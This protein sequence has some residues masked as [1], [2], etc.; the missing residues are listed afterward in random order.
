MKKSLQ[1]EKW[2]SLILLFVFAAVCTGAVND[3][4][5]AYVGVDTQNSILGQAYITLAD[6]YGDRRLQI[7]LDSIDTFSNFMI[8]YYNL[9]PRLQW[10]ATIYD[11]RS[12][13]IAGYDP[14]SFRPQ[15]RDQVYRYTAGEFNLQYPISTNYRLTGRVTRAAFPR[16]VVEVGR[17]S[18]EVD[19]GTDLRFS[20]PLAFGEEDRGPHEMKIW[21]G[22]REV[23]VGSISPVYVE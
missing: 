6:Q 1:K 22:D 12:F 11:S 17:K 19:L 4:S 14:V 21:L 15:S 13:Y 16:L 5:G 8:G 7:F 9:E 20:L 23:P 10:G 18:F 3:G 2:C